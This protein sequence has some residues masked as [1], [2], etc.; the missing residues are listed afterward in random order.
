MDGIPYTWTA[1]GVRNRLDRYAIIF[2][3]SSVSQ[4]CPPALTS[5]NSNGLV[6]IGDL[7]LHHIT[8]SNQSPEGSFQLWMYEY[9][10][11]DRHDQPEVWMNL[12]SRIAA[13][14]F[15]IAYPGNHSLD[16]GQYKLSF[17]LNGDVNWI[18]WTSKQ[19]VPRVVYEGE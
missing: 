9:S 6:S 3:S 19:G 16:G 17:H 7:W 14:Q 8:A 18:K 15:P 2:R 1:F 10:G 11:G 4:L 13:Q 5:L 12:Q